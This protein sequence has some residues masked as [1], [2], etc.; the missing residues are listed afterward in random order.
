MPYKEYLEV[1]EDVDIIV[2][3]CNAY[4]YGMNAILGLSLGKVVLSGFEKECIEEFGYKDSFIPIINI[5]PDANQIFTAIDE[6]LSKNIINNKS[7]KKIINYYNSYHNYK[8]V[9]QDFINVYKKYLLR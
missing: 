8:L 4:S 1:I 6:V 2:D 7:N 9:T 5:K 3:Q